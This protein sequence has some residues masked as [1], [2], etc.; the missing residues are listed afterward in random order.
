MMRDRGGGKQNEEIFVK[1]WLLALPDDYYR[2]W[3]MEKVV[4]E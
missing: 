1:F 3:W 4:R 2:R